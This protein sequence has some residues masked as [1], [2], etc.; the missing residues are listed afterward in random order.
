LRL[1]IVKELRTASLNSEFT[2]SYK[3]KVYLA[4]IY[5]I[6][7]IYENPRGAQPLPALIS[8]DLSCTRANIV[9]Q[10][11]VAH[12]STNKILTTT[13]LPL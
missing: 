9:K 6:C 7:T 5:Y 12:V 13:S 1:K 11:H 2:G 10:N 4:S 8:P 3:K